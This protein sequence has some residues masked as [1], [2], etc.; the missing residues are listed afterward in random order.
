MR[1][2]SLAII[3]LNEEANIE[4]CI[5]SVP[6]ASEVV[7]LDTASVDATREIAA[8]NG[9]RVFNEEWRG[10]RAQ[11][12]RAV[13]LCQNDWI[14]SLDADEALSPEAAEE[15]QKI[16][17]SPGEISVDGFDFPRLSWNLGRFIRHGGWYPDRQLRLFNRTKTSWQGGE[18]VHERVVSDRV[19]NLKNPILHWPF[20]THADQVAKNN[21]YSGLGALE[22]QKR[23]DHFSLMKLL[24]KPLT[25]FLETYLTKG[26]FLDGLPGFIISI[27]AAY[28]V[29]LKY[30]KLW[31]I[32]TAPRKKS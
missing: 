3:T 20:K 32:E 6:F 13:D 24:F 2:V 17:S 5:R 9:A 26:G 16:L 22:L 28:S 1:P 27:G 7:V 12:Q 30:V 25:K 31:E 21:R 10:F 19:Q 29:F 4:R 8:K 14:L 18:H 15:I 23:G 11:K